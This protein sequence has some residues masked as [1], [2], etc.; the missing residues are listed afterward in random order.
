MPEMDDWL[1]RLEGVILC[2]FGGYWKF[3]KFGALVFL[4]VVCLYLKYLIHCHGQIC[5]FP[6]FPRIARS[7]KKGHA[8]CRGGRQDWRCDWLAQAPLAIR[9]CLKIEYPKV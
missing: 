7:I 8:M 9:K 5:G 6:V 3:G 2:C 1:E 4:T